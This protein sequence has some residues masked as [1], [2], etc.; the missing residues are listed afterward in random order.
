MY[1]APYEHQRLDSIL[2]LCRTVL[3]GPTGVHYNHCVSLSLSNSGECVPTLPK[4]S[5]IS[6]GILETHSS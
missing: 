1:N 4:V 5:H 2:E 6:Y 3:I